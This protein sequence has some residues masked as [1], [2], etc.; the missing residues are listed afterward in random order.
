MADRSAEETRTEAA[1]LLLPLLQQM[2]DGVVLIEPDGRFSFA[3]DSAAR[4][5]ALQGSG[6]APFSSIGEALGGF[7]LFDTSG[8]PLP[9]EKLPSRLAQVERRNVEQLIRLRDRKSGDSRWSM[10]AATPAL[11]SAGN[12]SRVLTVFRD[13]TESRR[14]EEA[15]R[16]LAAAGAQL[17]ASLDLEHTLQAIVK[18]AVPVLADWCSLELVAPEGGS[19]LVAVAHPDPEMEKLAWEL[20]E[21]W[22]EDPGADSG[23]PKVLRT[24]QPEMMAVIPAGMIEQGARDPEHLR[25]L[26]RLALHSYIVVPLNARG[27]TLGALTLVSAESGREF[28]AADLDIA[29]SLASRAA[30]ALDNAQL[31]A[32]LRRTT[33]RLTV[34]LEAGRLGSWE[35][36]VPAN[37]IHWSATTERI[38][39][40]P[41]GSFDGSFDAYQSDTHPDDKARVEETIRATLQ[42][43]QRDYEITYRI[44]RPDGAVR[45]LEAR[46]A[47]SFD[48]A[49][50]PLRLTGVCADVTERKEAEEARQR[51]QEEQAQLNRKLLEAQRMFQT[52][53]ENLPSLAWS[54]L[55]DG[56]IDYYNRRWYDYTGT[57]FEQMEGWGWKRVH[58]PALLDEVTARWNLSLQSGQ[59]FEM[60]FPLRGADG[61]FRWF[62]TRVSPLRDGQGQIVRWFGTN[63]DIH[64]QREARRRTEGLLEAVSEQVREME[65]AIREMRAAKEAAERR[66]AGLRDRRG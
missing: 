56:H 62:L 35:W 60:E 15:L 45:W 10:I 55:P 47:L 26:R 25:L 44:V 28:G 36:D 51:A 34:A 12:V 42:K 20:R 13:R 52:L 1:G 64:E 17:N 5:L 37:R 66:A 33:E 14:A 4:L 9:P 23:V 18:A 11:D 43:R 16:F 19:R 30:V 31:H 29:G 22:P 41:E 50:N 48:A 7:E 59:P 49:G 3:N 58:D 21:K 65:G 27:R 8:A 53:V 2:S 6:S 38:H 24:G 46:G 57:T 63:V 54:A 61:Q 32:D 39:G 40:I